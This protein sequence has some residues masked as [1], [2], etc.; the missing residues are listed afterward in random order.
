VSACPD[1][2]CCRKPAPDVLERWG[3]KAWPSARV[4][5]HIFSPLPRGRFPGVSEA[6]VFEFL[7]RHAE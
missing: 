6:D 7:E 5:T 1:E 3:D 2:N 4:H